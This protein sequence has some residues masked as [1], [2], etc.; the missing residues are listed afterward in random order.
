MRAQDVSHKLAGKEQLH[1]CFDCCI[2]EYFLRSILG[3][4]TGDAAEEGILALQSC[5]ERYGGFE[6][7]D[8]DFDAVTRRSVGG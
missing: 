6:V 7:G 3:R 8:D 5:D 4:S 2:D 1:L